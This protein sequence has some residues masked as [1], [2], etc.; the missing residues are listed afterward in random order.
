M[1]AI[2]KHIKNQYGIDKNQPQTYKFTDE[3][4]GIVNKANLERLKEVIETCQGEIVLGGAQTVD[5]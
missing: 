2:L 5:E 3:V 1:K 4:G